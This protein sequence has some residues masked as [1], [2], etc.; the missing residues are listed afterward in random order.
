ME[1]RVELRSWFDADLVCYEFRVGGYRA[2][3]TLSGA[4]ARKHRKARAAMDIIDELQRTLVDLMDLIKVAD[5][6]GLPFREAPGKC[7]CGVSDG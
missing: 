4:S 3:T 5:E 7:K 6:E 2:S 1:P